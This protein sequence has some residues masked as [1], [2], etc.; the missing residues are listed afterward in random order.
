MGP[1]EAGRLLMTYLSIN[2]CVWM[3]MIV[4]ARRVWIPLVRAD[5]KRFLPADKI[6]RELARLLGTSYLARL[7]KAGWSFE[8]FVTDTR[9]KYKID[10][11]DSAVMLSPWPE[12]PRD[13]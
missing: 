4:F 13:G 1:H 12:L 7:G 10:T 8:T 9:Q 6:K 5:A 2:A 11:V 3:S